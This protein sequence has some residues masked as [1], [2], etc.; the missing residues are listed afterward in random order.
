MY[1]KSLKYQQ[2]ADTNLTSV[3]NKPED[4]GK[5]EGLS[6]LTAMFRTRSVSYFGVFQTGLLAQTLPAKHS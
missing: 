2:I 1:W 3:Q 4:Y 5:F 6:V